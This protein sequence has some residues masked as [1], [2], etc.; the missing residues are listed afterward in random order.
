MY[1]KRDVSKKESLGGVSM[2]PIVRVCTPS[3]YRTS[4]LTANGL[5][6]RQGHLLLHSLDAMLGHQ[7]GHATGHACEFPILVV[8]ALL[9]GNLMGDALDEPDG[10]LDSR[11]AGATLE[12]DAT[13]EVDPND[14]MDLR[15]LAVFVELHVFAVIVFGVASLYLLCKARRHPGREDSLGKGGRV[16]RAG[17]AL[18]ALVLVGLVLARHDGKLVETLNCLVSESEEQSDRARSLVWGWSQVEREV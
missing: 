9:G 4:L 5:C 17:L 3:V 10:D 13:W 8:D 18:F 1:F 12:S 2:T 14:P 15:E 6:N 7:R 11:C 16:G